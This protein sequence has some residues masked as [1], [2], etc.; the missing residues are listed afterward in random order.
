[1][2]VM[3]RESDGHL[4]GAPIRIH[5]KDVELAEPRKKCKVVVLSG[6]RRG[7]RGILKRTEGR[8]CIVDASATNQGL[9]MFKL[10]SVAW[11]HE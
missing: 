8:D 4:S 9:E 10:S 7:L 3:L 6:S 5:Y 2:S 1:M 11:A